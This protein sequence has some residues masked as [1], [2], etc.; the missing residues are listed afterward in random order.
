MQPQC[1]EVYVEND[2][3]KRAAAPSIANKVHGHLEKIPHPHVLCGVTPHSQPRNS[4][5]VV[6]TLCPPHTFH[7][8][9]HMHE[10][11]VSKARAMPTN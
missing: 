7:S 8:S 3:Y 10:P 5:N 4:F 11:T 9:L 2:E 1:C 6:C